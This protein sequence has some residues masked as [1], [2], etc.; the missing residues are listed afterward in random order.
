VYPEV[1]P[2]MDRLSPTVPSTE[3]VMMESTDNGEGVGGVIGDFPGVMGKTKS[4]TSN[5]RLE[6]PGL[7]N[8]GVAHLIRLV[9][10]REGNGSITSDIR[11]N[12]DLTPMSHEV[13]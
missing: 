3:A 2:A 12:P 9:F 7:I 6:G 10:W 5:E 11:A 13:P 1:G 8:G 4:P